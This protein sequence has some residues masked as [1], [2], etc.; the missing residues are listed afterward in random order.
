MNL[1]IKKYSFFFITTFIYNLGYSIFYLFKFY[2]KDFYGDE[3]TGLIDVLC[4]QISSTILL[5]IFAILN[6]VNILFRAKKGVENRKKLKKKSFD[7]FGIN[8]ISLDNK[9]APYLITCL[10]ILCFSIIILGFVFIIDSLFFPIIKVLE[11]P[12]R[13][14]K[15]INQSESYYGVYSFLFLN[16][17]YILLNPEES[18]G[19]YFLKFKIF[20]NSGIL[21]FCIC[22]FFILFNMIFYFKGKDTNADIFTDKAKIA[23]AM[24]FNIGFIINNYLA[25]K[26]YLKIDE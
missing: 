9:M 21:A 1:L 16:I 23:Y 5:I 6:P 4:F 17:G 13:F 11:F 12:F 10:F 8:I 20:V 3:G 19:I 18:M 26:G 24:F 14:A 15:N 2:S 25:E 7:I 22:A